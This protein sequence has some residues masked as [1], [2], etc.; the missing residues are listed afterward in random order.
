MGARSSPHMEGSVPA[1]K[2]PPARSIAGRSP[3]RK[4]GGRSCPPVQSPRCLSPFQ[5]LFP[6]TAM[7]FKRIDTLP[8]LH[9]GQPV[10]LRGKW[11]G[12]WRKTV[13]LDCSGELVGT[14]LYALQ[15]SAGVPQSARLV[16]PL[17]ETQG[18]CRHWR[19]RQVGPGTTQS[20]G[21]PALEGEVI[22]GESEEAERALAFPE[23][24]EQTTEPRRTL[25]NSKEKSGGL[26]GHF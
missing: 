26:P 14:L 10:G 8:G 21:D 11:D 9:E 18:P 6:C 13:I 23:A 20:L 3:R 24:A 19:R 22:G 16:V 17:G 25:R 12:T 5:N 1:R 4:G 2:R 7:T 15:R